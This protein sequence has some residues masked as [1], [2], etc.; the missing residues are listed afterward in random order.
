MTPYPHRK[1]EPVLF[2]VVSALCFA[3]SATFAISGILAGDALIFSASWSVVLSVA[4]G[5]FAWRAWVDFLPEPE[6]EWPNRER[7]ERYARR[8]LAGE[9]PTRESPDEYRYVLKSCGFD[10]SAPSDA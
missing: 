3:L 10:P 4:S 7:A 5:L 8:V 6:W 2:A 9:M 1:R